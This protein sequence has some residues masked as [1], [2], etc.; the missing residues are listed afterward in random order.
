MVE[1]L[2]I[3]ELKANELLNSDNEKQLINSLK[4]T[5]TEVGL[6]LNFGEI[7]GFKRKVYDNERKRWPTAR[8]IQS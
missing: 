1:D 6:L 3:W 5:N 7:P 8:N 4:A 2:V